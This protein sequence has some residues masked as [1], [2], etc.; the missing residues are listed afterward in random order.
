MTGGGLELARGPGTNDGF[1]HLCIARD[2]GHRSETA[3]NEDGVV[4][5]ASTSGQFA[6][7]VQS[8]ERLDLEENSSEP[9]PFRRKHRMVSIPLRW[10]QTQPAIPA[11]SST[12]NR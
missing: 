11:L 12:S 7:P 1:L 6:T 8:A 5:A 2:V 3:G 4:V 10:T 9:D